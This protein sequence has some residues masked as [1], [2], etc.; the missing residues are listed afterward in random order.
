[1][2]DRWS[3]AVRLM[4]VGWYFALC[5]IGGIVAG[6][7]LDRWLDTRPVFI[8]IGLF[9]GLALAFAGGLVLLLE[10]VREG[11]EKDGDSA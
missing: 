4:G 9:L 8:L 5:I 1:V 3:P 10:V 2:N 11:K 6:L 7:F